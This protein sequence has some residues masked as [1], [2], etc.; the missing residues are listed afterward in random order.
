MENFAKKFQDICY[1]KGL[2]QMQV[3][4]KLGVG[5]KTISNWMTGKITP[6]LP[7]IRHIADTFDVSVE[8]LLNDSEKI[9]SKKSRNPDTDL[10]KLLAI[11]NEIQKVFDSVSNSL[12]EID[13]IINSKKI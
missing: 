7:K 13:K 8:Y 3:A 9:I 1:K 6:N 5:Q 12:D 4:E 11:R 2:S 10:E